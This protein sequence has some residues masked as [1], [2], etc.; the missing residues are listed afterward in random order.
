MMFFPDCDELQLN[1]VNI[2]GVYPIRLPDRRIL[3][4]WCDTTTAHGGWTVIQRRFDGS[5]NFERDWED[6]SF[7][8][9]NV[10]TEYWIGNEILYKMTHYKNYTVR[11]DLWDWED[12]Y[13]YAEYDNFLVE[14]EKSQYMLHIGA[15]RGTAGDAMSSYHNKQKFSTPEEDNDRWFMNCAQKDHAGWWYQ[16]CGQ[17][18]LN[19]QYL[20]KGESNLGPGGVYSGI[21]WFP[22][23]NDYAHPLKRVEIK[24][25]SYIQVKIDREK[26]EE[27]Q[28]KEREELRRREEERIPNSDKNSQDSDGATTVGATVPS[29]VEGTTDTPFYTDDYDF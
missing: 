4:V 24:V 20:H 22:W 6:Y 8:F 9:G 29:L 28:R 23:H 2:S 26:E 17:A 10:N 18:S 7:G 11:F 14:G 13:R 25:K 3:N 27:M 19:G 1:G 16:A 5:V 21:I 15:Y 12:G